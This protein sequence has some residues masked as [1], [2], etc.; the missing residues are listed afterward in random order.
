M[1]I[2]RGQYWDEMC[3]PICTTACKC[4]VKNCW[5]KGMMRR[6]PSLN[7]KPNQNG[8]GWYPD[9]LTKISKTGPPKVY[10]MCWLGDIGWHGIPSDYVKMV[11]DELSAINALRFMQTNIADAINYNPHTALFLTKWPG[12]LYK[13]LERE[14]PV[15]GVYIGATITGNGYADRMNRITG[16]LRGWNTWLSIEPIR[17]L[18][19]LSRYN[20]T[21]ISQVIVGGDSLSREKDTNL[22][23]VR[24]V[25]EQCKTASVPVF[26][27]QLTIGGKCIR[28]INQ[29]PPDLRVREL[30]WRKDDN[31]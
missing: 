2:E 7:P 20:L 30:T 15:D 18:I 6:F 24:S 31:K 17:E 11:M 22:D 10:A 14:E 8:V 25:V 9:R 19:N 16:F 4:E 3:N 21:E 28:D 23:A 27:K 1:N 12:N 26:V 5:A 13:S 29:F